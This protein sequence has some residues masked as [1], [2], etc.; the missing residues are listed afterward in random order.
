MRNKTKLFV[1][2]P[3]ASFVIAGLTLSCSTLNG[4]GLQP[5]AEPG[6]ATGFQLSGLSINPAEVAARDEVV[7][8]AEV[9]NVTSVDD[10]YKSELKI[11]N[12]TE[13]SDKVLV[14]AGKTQTLTFVIFKDAPGTY[15]VSLGQLVSQF[16]VA[17]SIAAGPDNQAPAVPG[18]TG[19]GCC[20]LGNQTTS[21]ALGQTGAGCCGTG[22]QN[23][24]ATQP[25]P[26]GGCGCCGR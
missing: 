6:N 12:V 25:R 19:A 21:P 15:K 17:E 22:I 10:T 26:T 1:L 5:K 7:I 23:S 16:V 14:P 24:P 3:V 9:T 20:A 2:I 13:S 4:L 8:T 18:Q 11:N